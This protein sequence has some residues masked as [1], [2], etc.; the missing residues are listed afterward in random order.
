MAA[1]SEERLKEGVIV[2]VWRIGKRLGKGGQGSV[3]EVRHTKDRGPPRALKACFSRNDR[4]RERFVREV[5]LLESLQ[6]RQLPILALFGSNKD[7]SSHAGPGVGEFAYFVSERCVGSL[8]DESAFLGNIL[9]K[10]A[11]F[12][13]ACEAI[14]LLHELQEPV[15][16]RD[17][18]PSNFLRA[19]E[20]R[21]LVLGDFGIARGPVSD[22]T[23]TQEVV[24][25]ELYR[26]PEVVRGAPSAPQTEVYSL[27]RLLEWL[28]TGDVSRDMAVRD[29]PRSS[30]LADEVC[31]ALVRFIG[32]AVA[33]D[34]GERY[35]SVRAMLS[36]MPAVEVVLKRE[37]AIEKA[38]DGVVDVRKAREAL[39]RKEFGSWREIENEVRARYRREMAALAPN[40]E[41]LF[42]DTGRDATQ[43]VGRLLDV[44]LPQVQLSLVALFEGEKELLDVGRVVVELL[45]V[46]QWPSSGPTVVVDA[47][48]ALV[49]V[50][51]HLEGALACHL[52]MYDFV[53][54]MLDV[55]VRERQTRDSA[56]YWRVTDVMWAPAS[57]PDAGT[58]KFLVG[59]G[60]RSEVLGFFG[61]DLE[62]YKEA[63]ASY[64]MLVALFGLTQEV[65]EGR[66]IG[67]QRANLVLAGESRGVLETAF[68]RTI[69]NPKVVALL[70]A[71]TGIARTE[72]ATRWSATR[73]QWQDDFARWEVLMGRFSFD[74][75]RYGDLG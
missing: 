69:G 29:L 55:Q 36:A 37:Q 51:H 49:Y 35:Q 10:L 6:G 43:F 23:G 30:E 13:E 68:N 70:C 48:R 31:Q 61:D 12:R 26:A 59:L 14:A 63:L 64:L 40:T 41:R 67:T 42:S 50:F 11:V 65:S 54:S 25:S 66:S 45:Q 16:H 46:P 39:R 28:L 34:P 7:W 18:K 71:K 27:G 5:D 53:L 3:Y 52:G 74:S 4:E 60:G 19:S 33:A 24:G 1:V 17:I 9:Q 73:A 21:R 75:Y 38:P 8:E 72:L 2:G 32:R 44:A 56:P 58:W 22:L 62:V 20:P 57:L 47:P 15:L